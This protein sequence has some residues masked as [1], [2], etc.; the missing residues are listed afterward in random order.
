MQH[1]RS[2]DLSG[3]TILIAPSALRALIVELERYGAR[4]ICWPDIEIGHPEKFTALDEAIENLFG[5]DWLIFRNINAVDCFRRRFRELGRDMSD[6]DALSV[7]A[8]G[9][10]TKVR[11]EAFRIHVDVIPDRL[12]SV[13]ALGAIERY[14]GGRDSL[15][16]MN[17]LI[18]RAAIASDSLTRSLEAA[19]ARGDEV[20]TYSTCAADNPDLA[21]IKGLLS[22]GGIDCISFAESS[23]VRD[24]ATV[25]DTNDLCLLLDGVVVACMDEST[26][27]TT[28]QFDV[29]V[30]IRPTHATGEALA[31][32]VSDYVGLNGAIADH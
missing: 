6:L 22:G 10:A 29:H 12:S 5:Y 18:P 28:E 11:L 26:A 21:Q 15:A 27:K 14:V 31:Q 3:R 24:L 19:G 9:E 13:S 23:E 25:F 20:T 4:V 7:C 16:G 1:Y 17:F 32:A 2:K 8:I 30:D